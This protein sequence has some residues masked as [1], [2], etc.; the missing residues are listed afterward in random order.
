MDF[1]NKI[2][3]L[4][5]FAANLNSTW[6]KFKRE[7]EFFL[8]AAEMTEKSD[9]VK[10]SLLFLA[11][12]N[13]ATELL[14]TLDL[15]SVNKKIY[16]K[17]IEAYE[18]HCCL[19]K[20]IIFER[21]MFLSRNQLP[22]EPIDE[23]INDVRKLA[24]TCDYTDKDEQIRDRIILGLND[25]KL[26]DSIIFSGQDK[27]SEI[28]IKAR[29]YECQKKLIAKMNENVAKIDGKENSKEI[30]YVM[31][32]KFP[33]EQ[34]KNVPQKKCSRC[35]YTHQYRQC[36]AF[37]KQCNKCR[38][39][40]HFATVCRK[41]KAVDELEESKDEAHG[42]NLVYNCDAI[43]RYVNNE[44]FWCQSIKIGKKSI[45]FK[46]DTGAE[47]NTIPI[48]LLNEFKTNSEIKPSAI[49]LQAYFGQI[50]KPLGEIMLPL[51]VKGKIY[52]EKFVVVKQNSKPLLGLITC[53]NLNLIKRIDSI[54]KTENKILSD[55]EKFIEHYKQVF[56]GIG[57]FEKPLKLLIKDDA[58]PVTFPPRAIPIKV[59]DK[60]RDKLLEMEKNGVISRVNEQRDWIHNIVVVE[61]PNKI[62]LC[63][64]PKY[65][66]KALKKFPYP[67]PR[68]EEMKAE[69]ADAKYFT[70]LD[71]KDGFYHVELDEE[72]RKLCTFSTGFGLWQF[73]RLPFGISVASEVFQKYNN[74]TFADLPGKICYID[75]IL[76]F[77]Q[78]LEEHDNNLRKIMERALEK[79]VKFNVNKLQFTQTSVKYLGHIFS[80]NAISVDPERISGIVNIPEPKNVTDIQKFLG[81][82]GYLRDFI[83]NIP[84]LTVNLRSLTKN[85]TEFVWQPQHKNEFL[86]MKK[87]IQKTATCSYYDER[88]PLEIE[89]DASSYGLGCCLRQNK[90]IVAFSSRCLSDDEKEYG[91]IEKE[92]LGVLFACKK[93]HN[94][95][96]GREVVVKTDH[97]PLESIMIKDLSKI[98]SVRL[99][100]IRLKLY[101][102]NLQLDYK[103]GKK[104]PVADYL[105]RFTNQKV[106]DSY[107]EK[108]LSQMV[109]S[110]ELTDNL[111]AEYIQETNNDQE[112]SI[113]KKYYQDG[114]PNEKART[115]E[116]VKYYYNIK[117]EIY[118]SDGLIFYQDRVIIPKSLRHKVLDN[119]HEGHFGINKTTSLAKESVFWPFMTRDIE[120]EITKCMICNEN[121]KSNK[122]EPMLAHKIPNKAFEKIGCD[123][124]EFK[125]KNY[126]VL[127]DY[128]SKWIECKQMKN[129]TSREVI[130]IWIDIF[131]H[132][133]IPKEIIADNQPF[134]SFECR[135]F[136]IKL[137]FNIN[138]SSPRYP[139]SNGLAERAVG[140][141]KNIFKKSSSFDEVN[142]ALLNY[143]NMPVKDINI[144][145]AQLLQ[146]K[147]L[148]TRIVTKTELLEPKINV[149]TENKFNQKTLRT[150]Y[151]YN[152]NATFKKPLVEGQNIW[153][154]KE[155][156]KW[157]QGKVIRK[158][159]EPRSY[160]IELDNGQ[161]FRRNSIHL[162][163]APEQIVKS[164]KDTLDPNLLF[165]KNCTPNSPKDSSLPVQAFTRQN[166]DSSVL[167][168]NCRV[169]NM[170]NSPIVA[171]NDK[172]DTDN[173]GGVE[174]S[175][176]RYGRTIK[177]VKRLQYP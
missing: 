126:L 157:V 36:P 27:M 58:I 167:S 137:D 155:N 134:N 52:N 92:F 109:H 47:I 48:Q 128:Y 91:Q 59:R 66:N 100:R 162:R 60:V 117:D 87:V 16:K 4:D 175:T 131:S 160:E 148:R 9:E 90:R 51:N 171:T 12:G 64:D 163:S 143:R 146:N 43:K 165:I 153:M 122:K 130:S 173:T 172:T 140:I 150:E 6:Q 125:G 30:D 159:K 1:I 55:K 15:T 169:Q 152:R 20:N 37:G 96:Y 14:N 46:L 177:P 120:N 74:D 83:P 40:N 147:R 81:M 156:K 79:N 89:T 132:F 107:Q 29:S 138:T 8:I 49:T 13:E 56:E 18:K 145:P 115:H 32:K 102:Y 142:M 121:Q 110:V 65:L 123:I 139:R 144:S 80:H 11:M 28:I 72:T 168:S 42:E 129:K 114:W 93:F 113:I 57:K 22:E 105:S 97:R 44:K 75:D 85:T 73:N 10:L 76:I 5:I 21:F 78:T 127:I 133:G 41:N 26:R 68:F 86:N 124:C 3:A 119:L 101:R 24:T 61:K 106:A 54:V 170:Q 77:G 103:P 116:L 108:S 17:V 112:L 94:Y 99:Q 158:L 53:V 174:A 82:I 149:T 39:F 151:Y 154:Q 67:I 31:K 69:L 33:F 70:V 35:G 7:F 166:S 25:P 45:N 176:T 19:K 135:Q 136:S 118:Y 2:A 23:F 161:I 71:I 104:I 50:V 98:G 63:M 111:K 164:N 88:L 84:E 34:N 141:M 38:G 62:R 95:I